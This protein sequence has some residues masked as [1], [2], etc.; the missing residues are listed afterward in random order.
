[1]RKEK[2]LVKDVQLC[3]ARSMFFITSVVGKYLGF[4]FR[5]E[6]ERVLTDYIMLTQNINQKK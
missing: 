6:D 4:T 3:S 1:L 5:Y 2:I